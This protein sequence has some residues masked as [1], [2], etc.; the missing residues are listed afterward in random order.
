MEQYR[1]LPHAAD[2]KFR[3]FGETVEEAFANAALATASF[4]WDWRTIDPARAIAVEVAGRDLEQLLYKFLEEII[5]LFETRRFLLA[6]VEDLVIETAGGGRILRAAF[7][8]DEIG[9]ATELLG[10]VKAV[11]YSEM[12]IEEDCGGWTAQAVLDLYGA[13]RWS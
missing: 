2:G 3:S 10:E 12:K 4:M 7:R 1:I 11:T 6:A 9:P 13:G 5:Y 8:G